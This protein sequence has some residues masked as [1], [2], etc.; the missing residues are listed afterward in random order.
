V[1][2]APEPGPTRGDWG[3]LSDLFVRPFA[4]LSH[5][6]G[7]EVSTTPIERVTNRGSLV[8]LLMGDSSG[9]LCPV[10]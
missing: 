8:E 2:R 10:R 5:D 9:R 1:R 6:G 3:K 4:I 7:G